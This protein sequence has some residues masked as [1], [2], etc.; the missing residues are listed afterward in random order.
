MK[1]NVL[2]QHL[3]D[4]FIY[5]AIT[6]SEFLRMIRGCVKSGYFRSKV[7]RDIIEICYSYHDQFREAPKDHFHDELINFLQG[8]SDDIKNQCETYI[9]RVQEFEKPNKAYIIARVN[10][11]IQASEFENAM[12]KSVDLIKSDDFT[13]A[14][15][16]LQKALKAGIPQEQVGLKYFSEH[17]PTYYGEDGGVRDIVIPTGFPV[18]DRVI[19]GCYRKQLI[20]IFAGYKVG[21]TFGC[22]YLGRQGLM[23]GR[24]VLHISHESSL[25][26]VEMRYDMMLGS[27][28]S[29]AFETP[30]K[31]KQYD[32]SGSVISEDEILRGSIYNLDNIKS[33]HKKISRFG[34]DLIIQKYP[35]GSCTM[36][37]MERYLDYLET[38]ESFIPDVLIVDYPE[39]MRLPLGESAPMR[40]R[41]N[42]AYLDL[43]RIADERNIVV[44][45]A[46]QIKTQSL[47]KL[48]IS[49]KDAPSEDARKLGN[50]DL[51][52]FFS[53]NKV[54][55]QQ[56]RMKV[57]VLVN[58]SERMSFGCIS[59]RNLSVGQMCLDC[60]PLR[61]VEENSEHE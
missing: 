52:L 44:V 58:R 15:E 28:T 22:I 17:T 40:D 8:K 37:E 61:R 49:Q 1:D 43:K 16:L 56:G 34:G 48:D 9:S 54:Q 11:F 55:E 26:E 51:G 4:C 59:A 29:S 13:A 24:K 10:K 25:E 18:I 45:T 53:T 42:Q 20:C 19:G 3:Q 47:E 41:I 33:V 57:F 27:L 12:L 60:W 7:T 5:L 21:K 36:G 30:V 23:C 50:I 46:S 2:N 14:R 31:F 38:F 39:K 32:E 6:D 35:M